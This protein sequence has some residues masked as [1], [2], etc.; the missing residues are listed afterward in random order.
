[1]V[2]W[3]EPKSGIWASL[4]LLQLGYLP[5][6][7]LYMALQYFGSYFPKFLQ[8]EIRP[9]FHQHQPHKGITNPDSFISGFQKD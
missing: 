6:V 9:S 7:G 8:W 2:K 1:M 4:F 5:A 3:T